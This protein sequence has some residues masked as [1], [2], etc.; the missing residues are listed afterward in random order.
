[1]VNQLRRLGLYF[2]PLPDV[3]G[4]PDPNDDFLLGLAQAADA[5]LLVT[6][7]KS[8]LLALGRTGRTRIV[9]ARDL[10]DSLPS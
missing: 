5:D 7:D 8:H 9:T 10:V 1:M 3:A 2:D 4:S 6:G